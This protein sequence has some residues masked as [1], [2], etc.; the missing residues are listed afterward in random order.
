MIEG[1]KCSRF[2]VETGKPVGVLRQSRWQ[3]LDRHGAA[4]PGVGGA[5]DLAHA[6]GTERAGHFVNTDPLAVNQ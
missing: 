4:E 1:G 3:H 5:I 2:A 6:P